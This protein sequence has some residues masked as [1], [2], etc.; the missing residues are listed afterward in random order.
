MLIAFT[1]GISEAMDADMQEWG[2]E[3]LLGAAQPSRGLAP[4]VLIE[5]IMREADRFAAGADQH[6]EMTIVVVKRV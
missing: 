4:L 5:H 3:R 1:D 2:E 6:D